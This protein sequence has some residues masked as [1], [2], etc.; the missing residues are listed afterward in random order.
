[1]SERLREARLA[2]GLL[3]LFLTE[4]SLS[5]FVTTG[6]WGE[7]G[8]WPTLLWAAIGV[9]FVLE[10]VSEE[11]RRRLNRFRASRRSSVLV[12]AFFAVG[13]GYLFIDGRSLLGAAFALFLLASL[14][15]L[16]RHSELVEE[17]R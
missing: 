12:S 13:A 5:D 3:A 14:W 8:P 15:S 11:F 2:I 17:R 10:Y 6:R 7:S 4:L 9:V 1:M 16:R